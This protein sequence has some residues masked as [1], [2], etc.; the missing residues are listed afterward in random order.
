MVSSFDGG[1]TLIGLANDVRI[2]AQIFGK[3]SSRPGSAEGGVGLCATGNTGG[4][5][6]LN[7]EEY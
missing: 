1:S 3:L 5:N 2:L 6:Y 4:F 7:P